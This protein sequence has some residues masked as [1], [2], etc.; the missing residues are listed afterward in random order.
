MLTVQQEGFLEILRQLKCLTMAQAHWF[1]QVKYGCGSV[2]REQCLRQ[3]RYLNCLRF[4]GEYLYPAGGKL[5]KG[6]QP[7]IQIM[8]Q[9]AGKRLPEFTVGRELDRLLFYFAGREELYRVIHVPR[10]GE[11]ALGLRMQAEA[12]LKNAVRIFRL[13]YQEQAESLSF[14]QPE[15]CL[16]VLNPQGH[17]SF[18]RCRKGGG[19]KQSDA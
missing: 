4:E 16:A 2:K 1:L 11:R 19:A 5:D 14:V 15:D 17:W 18:L 6:L 13:E 7:E 8:L 3:L 12:A 10:G 9:I